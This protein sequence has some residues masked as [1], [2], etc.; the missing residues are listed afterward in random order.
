[1]APTTHSERRE[2]KLF[3]NALSGERKGRKILH[4]EVAGLIEEEEDEGQS[5]GIYDG[6]LKS[7]SRQGRTNRWHLYV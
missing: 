3:P 1:V 6:S 2:E 4:L 7:P 5:E